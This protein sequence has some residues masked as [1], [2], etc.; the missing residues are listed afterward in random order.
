MPLS[1]IFTIVII[2]SATIAIYYAIT[3][4]SQP[5]VIA[6]IYQARMNIGMGIFLLGVGTNQ[7]MFDD[8]DTIRLVI[9]IILLFIGAVNLIMGIRNLTYFTK[10]K[11]EQQNKR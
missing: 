6:R 11:R 2:L 5:G 3:W 7:L 8:V 1:S 10:L 4:R 9:G